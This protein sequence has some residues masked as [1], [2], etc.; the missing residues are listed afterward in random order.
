MRTRNTIR[1][2]FFSF[3]NMALT[4]LLAFF[5]RIIFARVLSQEYLGVSGLFTSILTV[6]SLAELGIGDAICYSLYEPLAKRDTEKVKALMQFYGKIYRLIGFGILLLGILLLPVYPLM[7]GQ[8][9]T[10]DHLNV[11]YLLFVLNTSVSYFGVYKKNLIIYD[12]H[13]YIANLNNLIFYG[14]RIVTQSILLIITK[15]YIVY[16]II[17]VAFTILENISIS[18]KADHSYPFLKEKSKIEIP[19]Q[20]IRKIKKNTYA[21]MLQKIGDALLNSMD[22]ILLSRLF[23]LVVAGVYSNYCLVFNSL[24]E[25]I[26]RLFTSAA[27]S[28]GNLNAS[29]STEK[30]YSS[31]KASFFIN[32][33]FAGLMACCVTASMQTFIKVAFGEKYLLGMGTLMALVVSFYL[34]RMRSATTSFRSATG[35]FYHGRYMTL[36]Q[37]VINIFASII[38]ATYFGVTGIFIGTSI[39]ILTTTFWLEP[40]LLYKYIFER[41][42]VEYFSIYAKYLIHT[43]VCTALCFWITNVIPENLIGFILKG[44][45]SAVCF[46]TIYFLTF[47]K[48]KEM[49]YFVDRVRAVLTSFIKI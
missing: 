33:Y 22:N 6:L 14:A 18:C 11:I 48:N 46:S 15:N 27:A 26:W 12:Q 2:I 34:N 19:V 45:V 39:S 32:A 37:A 5:S 30:L 41:P 47:R 7:I 10:I 1:N 42:L 35:V 38:C 40:M 8:T 24:G 43:I 13:E 3:L 21:I 29:E 17:Q 20:E 49:N 28:I 25:I 23:G 44:G 16:L 36:I 4:T 31:F 9:V